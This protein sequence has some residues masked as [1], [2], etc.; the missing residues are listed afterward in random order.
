[1][2]PWFE[3]ALKDIRV[4]ETPGPEATARIA[5]YHKHTSLKA[6][7][8]EISWCASSLNCWLEEAGFKGTGSAAARSFLS[9]GKEI[10]VPIEGCIVVLRRGNNPEQGHVGIYAG[11]SPGLVRVFAGNQSDKVCYSRFPKKDVL[12][13][14]MP[15]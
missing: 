9:W 6:T 12:G 2:T 13:Y 4:H 14:R 5:E 10:K 15:A 7:S 8:D 1:M 3:I 11:E